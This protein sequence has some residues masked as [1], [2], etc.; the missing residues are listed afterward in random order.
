MP[1][2]TVVGAASEGRS[3]RRQG[4]PLA[5]VLRVICGKA[6]WRRPRPPPGGK[7]TLEPAFLL[8]RAAPEAHGGPQAGGRRVQ[9][10]LQPPAYTTAT[11]DPSV[12]ATYT[13]A[14][15]K[16]RAFTQVSQPH[17]LPS[18]SFSL[19]QDG[20]CPEPTFSSFSNATKCR[21]ISSRHQALEISRDSSVP[22]PPRFRIQQTSRQVE[23]S[24]EDASGL[25]R[26]IRAGRGRRKA[27][28]EAGP[29]WGRCRPHS[30]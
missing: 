17:V 20:K 1:R 15:S 13:T 8:S 5:P 6:N 12:S 3:G 27:L 29:F 7:T 21:E 25:P 16:A 2:P 9:P 19:C 18:Y 30:Q 26:P 23:L 14:H 10:E 11:P 28:G 22:P 4:C 24:R